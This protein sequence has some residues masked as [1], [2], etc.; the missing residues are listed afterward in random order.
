MIL[1]FINKQTSR[2]K[3]IFTQL[4]CNYLSID[5]KFTSSIEEFVSYKG[6]K[7]SYT[8]R[9]LGSELHFSCHK[10]LF[11]E[12]ISYL[13]ISVKEYEGIPCF[14]YVGQL[15]AFPYDIFAASFYLLSRYE[16][17]LPHQRDEHYRFLS[18]ESIAVKNNFIHLPIVDIWLDKIR[19]ILEDRFE[20][21]FRKQEFSYLS[22]I[23]V[24]VAYSYIC[25]GI[26]R[27][28]GG[29]FVDLIKLDFS[30]IYER[31]LCELQL[32]KDPYDTFD[33][34]LE[35]YKKYDINTIFFFLVGDYSIFDKNI[36][37]NNVKFQSLIKY[38]ADYFDVGL[39][40]SYASDKKKRIIYTEIKRLQKV[41]NR[42]ITKSK[43]HFSKLELPY[44]Y[45]KL[46]DANIREDYSMGYTD[47]IG[48][49]SGT[50]RPFYFYDLGYE[51]TTL[52]KVYPLSI[53]DEMLKYQM[54]LS[55]QKALEEIKKN[56]DIIKKVNGT[57]ISVWH[58]K[59]L[60]MYK[61][62]RRWRNIY[63]K[64]IEYTIKE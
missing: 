3:Y 22:I 40:V 21:I 57:Y 61:W 16:E 45:R 5:I 36:S 4:L 46:I 28:T 8:N 12:D 6:M 62:D 52:L 44:T 32:K 23:N 55:P 41:L 35:N 9:P 19:K 43:Q 26:V 37:I 49:R 33:F 53:S 64:M 51:S 54:R 7:M 11:E 60:S 50:S 47:R 1:I 15:S 29:I 27:T 63:M 48:F 20:Y 58:N 31:I 38:I 56:I 18:K 2:L 42:E 25:K 13:D 24:D 39:C 34:I 10:L 17:Y 30:K 14:F 59:N